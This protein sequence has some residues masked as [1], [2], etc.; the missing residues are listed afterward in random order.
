MIMLRKLGRGGGRQALR[1]HSALGLMLLLLALFG[2]GCSCRRTV[3]DYDSGLRGSFPTR[4]QSRNGGKETS[5]RGPVAP[6]DSAVGKGSAGTAAEGGSGD[7]GES[8]G[9]G[10][11]EEGA[12]NGGSVAGGAGRAEAEP[13]EPAPNAAAPEGAATVGGKGN[14]PV[15]GNEEQET[16]GATDIPDEPPAALPG[17]P[18]VK[19]RYSAA[20]AL[21]IAEA[22]LAVATAARRRNDLS[23][24]YGAALEAF[25]AV[26]P[27]ADGH[28]SCRE[29]AA[30][31]N[32]ML[33]EVADQQGR[34]YKPQPVITIF[35]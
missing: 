22:A 24:A 14:Q 35:E 28:E 7:G 23:A 27:H 31:A 1:G 8:R 19:P 9:T 15:M 6:P 32:R 3:E 13:G 18:A 26:H 12:G 4:P 34:R 20:D 29:L 21:P 25:E 10:G 11:A 5:P 33:K 16:S 30:R 17:R 2:G